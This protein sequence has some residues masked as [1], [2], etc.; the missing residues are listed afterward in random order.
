MVPASSSGSCQWLPP[1][2][3]L[4]EPLTEFLPVQLLH[5]PRHPRKLCEVR[6]DC[7]RDIDAAELPEI[8]PPIANQ[9]DPILTTPPILWIIAHQIDVERVEPRAARLPEAFTKGAIAS[10]GFY[11]LREFHPFVRSVQRR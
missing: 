8:V 11:V 1:A 4:L 5:L 10:Q 6:E 9:P 7:V 3:P 2:R